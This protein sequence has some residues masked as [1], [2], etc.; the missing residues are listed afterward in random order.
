MGKGN[1]SNL[2]KARVEKNDEFYTRLEDIEKELKYYRKHFEDKVVFCNCDDPYESNFFKF[3]ALN[4][5]YFKLKK[6][7]ATCYNGSPISGAEIPLWVDDTT[8]EKKKALKAVMIMNELY[9]ANG[10]GAIDEDDVKLMLQKP[11]AVTELKGNGSFD[12]PECLELLKES[13]IVCTNP[14]FSLFRRFIEVMMEYNK[15]FLIIGN[16]NAVSYKDIFSYIKNNRLW[17]GIMRGDM[18]FTVPDSY[19]M[20]ETRSWR[21]ESGK[22]M[23]SIGNA[24]WFTNLEHS[25]R[26]EE[27]LIF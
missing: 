24:C 11:G 4:F 26:N 15:K 13:D 18:S 25:K 21:D 9:D 8:G 23:R 10:D 17:L 14:P 22:N 6:L 19:E 27:I 5:N 3:F 1:N 16:M 7:I 2:H 20:R 12:S